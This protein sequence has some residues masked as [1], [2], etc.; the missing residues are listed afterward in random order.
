MVLVGCLGC[1]GW[2]AAGLN[3]LGLS[4]VRS[5]RTATGVLP[6]MRSARLRRPL[7]SPPSQHSGA[8]R[9]RRGRSPLTRSHS[10]KKSSSRPTFRTQAALDSMA[11]QLAS[12]SAGWILISL[13]V[14]FHE[15]GHFFTAFRQGMHINEY[16]IGFGPRVLSRQGT[17]SNVTFSLRLLPFGG[18][19]SFPSTRFPEEPEEGEIEGKAETA[20]KREDDR[21]K[22]FEKNDPNLLENRPIPQQ[23][24]VA[25]GGIL[26][27]L[28]VAYAACFGGALSGI[29]DPTYSKGVVVEQVDKGGGAWLA[30]LENG[31]V[32]LK[33]GDTELPGDAL[34]SFV[35]S[36]AAS[37]ELPLDVSIKRE[38]VE[39]TI[40][41]TVLPNK[42]GKIMVKVKPNVA[43]MKRIKPDSIPETV[44][45]ANKQYNKLITDIISGYKSVFQ[46]TTKA[47]LAGPISMAQMG[48]NSVR[49]GDVTDTL[50]FFAALNLNLAAAN[51][52]PVPGLDGAKVVGLLALAAYGKRQISPELQRTF[53]VATEVSGLLLVLL[54]CNVLISDITKVLPIL[55]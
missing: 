17:E 9:G 20:A 22:V 28:A 12:N 30:G 52:L 14:A 19:V 7:E 25:M 5:L 44:S 54:V 51:A 33:V 6:H 26:A 53:D 36:V 38:G 16:S 21:F 18:F 34:Q 27:N 45:V 47:E 50:L 40:Q 35:K 31:D 1:L 41:K 39:E 8:L 48:S 4:D 3:N 15:G 23:I 46:G 29:P 13:A 49:G 24:L 10:I 11:S 55:K 32:I 37:P 2:P 43:E 42:N